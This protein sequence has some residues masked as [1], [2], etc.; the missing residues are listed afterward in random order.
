MLISGT[1]L[2]SMSL[3][4]QKGLHSMLAQVEE[5][6]HDV[7][8]LLPIPSPIG[9]ALCVSSNLILRFNNLII[10]Q[11]CLDLSSPLHIHWIHIHFISNS[12]LI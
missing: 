9:G 2:A 3:D 4:L 5:L 8:K 7:Y 10:E 6:P 11:V 1:G 12:C